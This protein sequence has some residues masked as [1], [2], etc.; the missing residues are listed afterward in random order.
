MRYEDTYIYQYPHMFSKEELYTNYVTMEFLK[1]NKKYSRGSLFKLK[2]HMGYTWEYII[3][4]I[5][6][7]KFIKYQENKNS[8]HNI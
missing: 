3:F 7:P 1:H 2:K 8:F 5:I 4:Y 6:T